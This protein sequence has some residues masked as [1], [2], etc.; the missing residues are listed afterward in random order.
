MTN[1]IVEKPTKAEK[2]VSQYLTRCFT[3]SGPV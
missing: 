2:S 3:V 1:E